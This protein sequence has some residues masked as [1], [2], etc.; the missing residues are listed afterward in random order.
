MR[1]SQGNLQAL[2][3]LVAAA[4][5]HAVEVRATRLRGHVVLVYRRGSGGMY[6]RKEHRRLMRLRDS[7]IFTVDER[8]VSGE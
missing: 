1:L 7:R 8:E 5:D 3:R 2:L 6:G 4:D